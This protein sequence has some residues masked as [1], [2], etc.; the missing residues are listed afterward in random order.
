MLATTTAMLMKGDCNAKNLTAKSI[1]IERA[2][3]VK[4]SFAYY[5]SEN[6]KLLIE[7]ISIKLILL[8]Q[9][10]V[11]D[12][13]TAKRSISISA[14]AKVVRARDTVSSRFKSRGLAGRTIS[15]SFGQ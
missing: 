15:S 1:I 7:I 14:S 2:K 6:V 3:Q 5:F 10:V 4:F 12:K 13:L 8:Y 11:T 9:A